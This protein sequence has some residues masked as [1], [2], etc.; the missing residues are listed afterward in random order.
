MLCTNCDVALRNKTT[1]DI[2][3]KIAAT[4]E[5]RAQAFRLVYQSYLKAGLGEPNRYEMRVTPY[6]LLSSTEI[7]TAVCNGEAIFTVSLVIDGEL[8][9]PMESVYADEVAVR[10]EQGLLTG[11]VSCLA[12]RREH[13]RGFFPVFIRISRLMVQYARQRGLDELLVAVHPKHARFYRRFMD[14]QVI[15]GEAAYPTVRNRPAVALNLNFDRVD[16][17]HPQS[18]DTFFGER[19]PDE[20]L[21]PHPIT[22]TQREYFGQMLDP[23]FTLA[24]LGDAGGATLGNTSPCN[25]EADLELAV[26]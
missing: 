12:D 25:S 6:H 7:F 20:Q 9:L 18:Y 1:A 22:Q 23:S 5:E 11:E 17:E 8:G 14:F 4:T 19:L 26:A 13:L 2:E 10:R 24:P 21:Q 16:Q 3:Y 15:G